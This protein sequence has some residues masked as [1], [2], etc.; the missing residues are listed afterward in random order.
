MF[1]KSDIVPMAAA[2]LSLASVTKRMRNG[3]SPLKNQ[4]IIR[5]LTKLLIKHAFYVFLENHNA[6]VYIIIIKPKYL[7]RL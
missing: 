5:L 6:I 3:T 1:V 4:K 2:F 7:C